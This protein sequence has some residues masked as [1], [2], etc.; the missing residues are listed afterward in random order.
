MSIKLKSG[1][2]QLLISVLKTIFLYHYHRKNG[3]LTYVSK[4]RGRTYK[5]NKI[6]M[7]YYT[8]S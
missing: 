6:G 3:I 2:N 8:F 5:L 7:K 4:Y 1:A